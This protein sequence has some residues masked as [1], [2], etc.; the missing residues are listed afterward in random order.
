MFSD[1]RFRVKSVWFWGQ[2]KC[3]GAH[4]SIVTPKSS[5]HAGHHALKLKPSPEPESLSRSVGRYMEKC[6]PGLRAWSLPGSEGA[7]TIIFSLMTWPT[8]R[9]SVVVPL[10]L[11]CFDFCECF[12]EQ[13]QISSGASGSAIDMKP[14]TIKPMLTAN[15]SGINIQVRGR[16]SVLGQVAAAL[17]NVQ[18]RRLGC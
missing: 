2:I 14:Y 15:H 4:Y 3:S 6:M 7:N 11:R 13:S 12:C 9:G 17:P 5:M 10:K 18:N 1:C 16:V 8:R